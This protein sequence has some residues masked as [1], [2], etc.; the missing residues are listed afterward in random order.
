M[1]NERILYIKEGSQLTHSGIDIDG[2]NQQAETNAQSGISREELIEQFISTRKQLVQRL[3]TIPLDT[4]FSL[5]HHTMTLNQFIGGLIE[6]DLHH[7]QQ[8]VKIYIK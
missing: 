5:G 8:I 6:H 3:E 2:V 7:I 4:T 1:L